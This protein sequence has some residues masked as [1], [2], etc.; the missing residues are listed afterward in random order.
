MDDIICPECGRPNLFEAE[1]CWYCQTNLQDVKDAE[2]KNGSDGQQKKVL[3]HLSQE[4]FDPNNEPE[5]NIPEWLK[6]VRELKEADK[7]LEE[8]D[9][10]WQQQNLFDS[11]KEPQKK[12]KTEKKTPINQSLGARKDK[13]NQKKND[14]PLEF[15]TTNQISKELDQ[16]VSESSEDL[17]DG[18]TKL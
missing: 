7:P 14:N 3:D 4:E 10:G 16:E 15:S 18:F 6:R 5:Q 13:N 17:P 2:I 1:K 11:E 9:P 8:N 12:N